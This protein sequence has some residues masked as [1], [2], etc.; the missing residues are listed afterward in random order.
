M[1]R[2][3]KVCNDEAKILEAIH[4]Y[5]PMTSHDSFGLGTDGERVGPH[6]KIGGMRVRQE[7]MKKIWKDHD[8]KMATHYAYSIR[9]SRD[10]IYNWR[11][12]KS[13]FGETKVTYTP[14]G[15]PR[16][17]DNQ[18][19]FKHAV[20][21]YDGDIQAINDALHSGGDDPLSAARLVKKQQQA[22]GRW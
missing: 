14:G 13:R 16:Y 1:R 7:L 22:E 21:M 12:I 17:S 11:M 3:L 10:K 8:I 4:A 9:G 18:E 2:I 20:R 15:A 19:A 6:W 5:L